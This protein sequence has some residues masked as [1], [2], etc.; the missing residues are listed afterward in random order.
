MASALIPIGIGVASLLGSIFSGKS[1]ENDAKKALAAQSAQWDAQNAANSGGTPERTVTSP[2]TWTSGPGTFAP[3]TM[4]GLQ[5]P[6]NNMDQLL[7]QY[8]L[9]SRNPYASGGGNGG[10]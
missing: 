4:A 8:M 7:T 6:S 2:D 1:K 5:M 10:L 3:N 9:R